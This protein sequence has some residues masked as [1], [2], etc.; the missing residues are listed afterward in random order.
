[1]NRLQG[2]HIIGN[3]TFTIE[4][5]PL[6]DFFYE[7]KRNN[8]P[9]WD[10][11]LL[12]KTKAEM[13]AYVTDLK[14]IEQIASDLNYTFSVREREGFFVHLL[15]FWVKKERIITVIFAI[16]FLFFISNT[17]WNVTITGVST[18]IENEIER[19]LREMGIYRGAFVLNR[20]DVDEVET[21]I[22]QALPELLYINVKKRGTIYEI[23]AKEKQQPL[24]KRVASPSHL[25]AKK[26]GIIKKM[27][28]KNGQIVVN[29][30]DFVK[31]GDLLVSGIIDLNENEDEENKE[32][33]TMRAEGKVYANTWY[34]VT[35]S[36]ELFTV[37][38][39][40]EG[41][42]IE[43]RYLT[44]GNF[45]LPLFN[46][47]KPPYTFTEES[48]Q[49]KQLKLFERTLPIYYVKKTIYDKELIEIKRTETEAKQLA[50]EHALFDLQQKLGKDAEILKYYILHEAK[51]N[52]KVKLRL[53][54][55][56]LENIAQSVPIE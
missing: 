49:E 25:V 11:H 10:I 31:K 46:F 14:R 16:L 22:K 44:V 56:T 3:V 23:E 27:L 1:M 40:L 42:F 17:I 4:G 2:R 37:H 41:D 28:I 47:K 21:N 6:V 50:I 12:G 34:E 38:E 45:T 51:E 43:H 55:S 19:M 36:S 5:E 54:V 24:E 39:R 7:A 18:P 52:G 29:V 30:N 35:V 26:S 33:I 32:K 9:L 20:A 48:I 8:I 15:S 53:Y 13:K